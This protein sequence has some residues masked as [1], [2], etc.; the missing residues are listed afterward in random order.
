MTI[1]VRLHRGGEE[2]PVTLKAHHKLN[3]EGQLEPRFSNVAVKCVPHCLLLWRQIGQDC[4]GSQA[5]VT[6]AASLTQSQVQQV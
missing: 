4:L 3:K 1:L 5:H 2:E 6:S